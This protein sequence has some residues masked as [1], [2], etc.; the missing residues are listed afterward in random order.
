LASQLDPSIKVLRE[1]VP[2]EQLDILSAKVLSES[3]TSR[4]DLHTPRYALSMRR[5]EQLAFVPSFKVNVRRVTGAGD[6]WSAG[7]LV[8]EALG[9]GDGDRLCFAHAVAA[10]YISSPDAKHPSLQEV[11]FFLKTHS[12]LKEL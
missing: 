7:D 4:I 10:L 1:S 2:Q 6:A 5:G 12:Y 11:K 8:G 9:L 3:I